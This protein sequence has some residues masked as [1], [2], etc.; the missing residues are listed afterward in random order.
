MMSEDAQ[1]LMLS[2]IL[3]LVIDGEAK[4]E[5]LSPGVA[6][7]VQ[8]ILDDFAEDPDGELNQQLYWF[9]HTALTDFKKGLH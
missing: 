2:V 9:A 8:G 5:E 6:G 3:N 1:V 4:L 7:Y